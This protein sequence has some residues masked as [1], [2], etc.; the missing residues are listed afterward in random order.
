MTYT[1]ANTHLH[2][3]EPIDP[4]TARKIVTYPPRPVITWASL[5]GV[6]K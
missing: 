4:R 2:T 6:P 3:C 5:F 1:F